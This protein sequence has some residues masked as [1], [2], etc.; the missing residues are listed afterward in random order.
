MAIKIDGNR[1]TFRSDVKSRS[2]KRL[3]GLES[4]YQG[5]DLTEANI[6][7]CL[8]PV[9]GRD[10]PGGNLS[11]EYTPVNAVYT[12]VKKASTIE[13]K[14][15]VDV[16]LVMDPA[17]ATYN[18]G[19]PSSSG[20]TDF[21]GLVGQRFTIL[22]PLYHIDNSEPQS[23][24]FEFTLDV[25]I[26]P[27]RMMM[28]NG[29]YPGSKVAAYTLQDVGK[30]PM[31]IHSELRAAFANADGWSDADYQERYLRASVLGV[32]NKSKIERY[33]A[34]N[35]TTGRYEIPLG[36]PIDTFEQ[37]RRSIQVDSVGH[38]IGFLE[39]EQYND[40]ETTESIFSNSVFPEGGP[41]GTDN[42]WPQQ[43]GQNTAWLYLV[44][45]RAI[46][47]VLPGYITILEPSQSSL[48]EGIDRGSSFMFWNKKN[49]NTLTSSSSASEIRARNP[50]VVKLYYKGDLPQS[51]TGGVNQTNGSDISVT[52][53][54]L[55]DPHEY[56]FEGYRKVE[57]EKHVFYEDFRN[58]YFQTTNFNGFVVNETMDSTYN[59]KPKAG[60]PNPRTV[61][62]YGVQLSQ[63][64]SFLAK[65]D[66]IVSFSTLLSESNPSGAGIEVVSELIEIHKTQKRDFIPNTAKDSFT[67]HED[68]H[69]FGL[70]DVTVTNAIGGTLE[71]NQK[72]TN[73]TYMEKTYKQFV[74]PADHD[75]NDAAAFEQH[76]VN[77]IDGNYARD[78]R[79]SKFPMSETIDVLQTN[80]SFHENMPPSVLERTRG[81]AAFTSQ[82]L[83]HEAA[84]LGGISSVIKYKKQ[85]EEVGVAKFEDVRGIR[86][87]PIDPHFLI[88][89]TSEF[90]INYPK[91]RTW[92]AYL[93][94]WRSMSLAEPR[95][96]STGSGKWD[97]HTQYQW[98]YKL[99]TFFPTGEAEI[100]GDD[101][102][103][104]SIVFVEE[105]NM[106]KDDE[107]IAASGA[108]PAGI[109]EHN[110]MMFLDYF[111]QEEPDTLDFFEREYWSRIDDTMLTHLSQQYWNHDNNSA[112]PEIETSRP[113]RREWQRDQYLY[114]NTGHTTV[115]SE[116][117]NGIISQEYKR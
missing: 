21:S 90:Q 26:D 76:I 86:R 48:P 3:P 106:I 65:G 104:D 94:E 42:Y 40:G 12:S 6:N 43:I 108:N 58:D 77:F 117:V 61:G 57:R 83:D 75:N 41:S 113:E 84:V 20:T 107:R 30:H 55:A 8:L 50:L 31:N 56:V 46:Y 89:F 47:N 13:T 91:V 60:H 38:L 101:G 9:T 45:S 99:G 82:Y 96:G 64:S 74:N 116:K 5:I 39:Y 105:T 27:R 68:R 67:F 78:E 51:W 23:W 52:N 2:G 66:P 1:K 71:R 34:Y 44:I 95:R 115:H 7:R 19:L 111:D 33:G 4:H 14:R 11:H 53:W 80:R 28:K 10:N 24:T 114:A 88:T 37:V 35:S 16:S 97:D 17:T 92:K 102:R 112:T 15:V 110:S 81:C 63:G 49:P 54:D 22:N 100:E 103:I 87:E 59:T 69:F 73:W 98:K 36:L 18:N 25:G 85:E 79:F 32:T 29:L 70:S 72:E 62:M 93:R 109:I